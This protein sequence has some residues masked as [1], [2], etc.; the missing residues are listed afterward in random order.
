MI[1]SV[2]PTLTPPSTNI[3]INNDPSAG[4]GGW[5]SLKTVQGGAQFT[6]DVA[7]H[8]MR[9]T[10]VNYRSGS[11]PVVAVGS[12]DAGTTL[13]ALT[14]PA[15]NGVGPGVDVSA[16]PL[17]KTIQIGGSFKGSVIIEASTDG[18]ATYGTVTS[19]QAGAAIT[20]NFTA[21]FMRVRRVGVD[22]ANVGVPIVNVAA[23][24]SG[25]GGGGGGLTHDAT[26][27]GLG[28][29]DSPLGVAQPYP[30]TFTARDTI[31]VG[32]GQ[33]GILYVLG[34]GAN[35]GL[36]SVGAGSS[37]NAELTVNG[38]AT[39]NSIRLPA[40]AETE[41]VPGATE[42][43]WTPGG[44]LSNYQKSPFVRMTPTVA[45]VISGMMPGTSNGSA[46]DYMTLRN[47]G[48]VNVTLLHE[49]ALSTTYNR[50]RLPGSASLVI[51]PNASVLFC[52][53]AVAG[54]WMI[55]A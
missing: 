50:F 13:A 17:I 2:D 1:V 39:V 37:Y 5:Q 53:D 3:E 40:T 21:D 7:C 49:S 48:T 29:S 22:G 54:R 10:V 31:M 25:A 47:M 27:G 19:V 23:C 55:A 28:T 36:V 35:G 26:L 44:V 24:P 52:Y 51:Q 42:N 32:S 15:D 6:V 12:D 8:W 11:G 18:G 16:L 33:R 45:S 4:A 34:S 46:F 43:N 14:A 9:A 41:A 30:D 20:Q 38:R